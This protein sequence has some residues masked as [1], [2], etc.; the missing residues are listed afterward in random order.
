M[1]AVPVRVPAELSGH[2]VL[3]AVDDLESLK[4]WSHG[5]RHVFCR[6]LDLGASAQCTME[7][8]KRV[9]AVLL[10]MFCGET[11]C[12]S[13]VWISEPRRMSF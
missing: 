5:L 2:V 3:P 7:T 4:R 6:C 9:H 12:A 10:R 11:T 8:G 1:Q 13:A